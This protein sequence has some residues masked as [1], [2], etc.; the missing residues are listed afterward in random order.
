M[1]NKTRAFIVWAGIIAISLLPVLLWGTLGPGFSQAF[2]SYA[3]FTHDF[4]VLFGL[5]GMTMFALTFVFSTKWGFIENLVGGLDKS[6]LVHG[7]LG[8]TALI[9]IMA[10]PIFLVLRFI[11][12]QMSTAAKYILPSAHFWNVN[13][14]IIALTGFIV[15]IF[16]TLFMRLKYQKWKFSH[17]FLGGVF[18][19]AVLHTLTIRNGV[20]QGNIFTGYMT[21]II[22]ISTLGLV[23]FFY[24]L[25]FHRRPSK[26]FMYQVKDIKKMAD[27]FE[28]T[29]SPKGK[30]LDYSA[31]QFIFL[32]FFNRK[33]SKEFHPFSIA[34]KS[35]AKNI[36]IV[37]KKLGDYTKKLDHLEVGDDVSIRGPHGK[38]SY[39]LYSKEKQVWIAAGVGI[40]PFLGMAQ[41]VMCDNN[42][43]GSV[44]LFYSV[45]SEQSLL[46]KEIFERANH[47]GKFNFYPWFSDKNG[48]INGEIIFEKVKRDKNKHF[49]ICGSSK[50][51]EDI[52]KTL[53]ENEVSKNNI[54]EEA[55]DFK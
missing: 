55:F 40:T 9:T 32:R 7:V 26:N 45:Q 28:I 48:R 29:M 43:S 33:L 36:V 34:S 51:K 11:P 35:N 6:Y 20:A 12:H 44:D 46:G 3:H 14:G 50:F 22:I 16:M 52:I 30:E 21:Y 24:S 19:L 47:S 2:S 8:G 54:H 42:F 37:V 13:F 4:G 27:Y 5:I 31:G 17:E 49:F 38:F 15:L 18:I 53:L 10:H 39:K 25:F 41:D 1:K 23:S